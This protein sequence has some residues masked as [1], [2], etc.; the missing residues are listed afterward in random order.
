MIKKNKFDKSLNYYNK[1]K[2]IFTTGLFIYAYFYFTHNYTNPEF[3]IRNKPNILIPKSVYDVRRK[4]YIYWEQSRI[5]RGFN[6]TFTY[7]NYDN[8]T[9]NY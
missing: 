4:H 3:E 9:V 1:Y 8:E 6:K 2:Y 5:A 7:F